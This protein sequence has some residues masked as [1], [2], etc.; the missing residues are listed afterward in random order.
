MNIVGK[1]CVGILALTAL[2]STT[3]FSLLLEGLRRLGLPSLLVTQLGFLYRYIFVLIDESM[4]IRR[5]RDFRGVAHATAGRRLA[6]VG[7]IIGSLFVRTMDRSE[8]IHAAMCARGYDGQPR[9]LD[10]LRF[11]TAEILFLVMTAFY[12][13]ACRWLL[14]RILG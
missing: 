1:L 11:R 9:S 8:R 3:P 4:R 2:M 13:V 6:A 12:L 5:A 14:P 10:R 7:G